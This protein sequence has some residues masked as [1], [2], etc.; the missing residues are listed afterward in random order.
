MDILV[1]VEREGEGRCWCSAGG[2][3]AS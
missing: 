2:N 1:Q 3:K